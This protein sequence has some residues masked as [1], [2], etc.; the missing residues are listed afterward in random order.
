[1]QHS[2]PGCNAGYAQSPQAL[3]FPDFV[4]VYFSSR[5]R[6]P[7]GMYVS[8]VAWADFDPDFSQ[9]LRTAREPVLSRGGLGCFDEHGV[10]PISPLRHAGR[11][12]GYTTGWSRRASVSVDTGI[13]LVESLDG[14]AT[15]IRHHAGPVLSSSL[16]EP[17]LVGDGFVRVHEGVFHMWYI[18]GTG[19]KKYD[20][21][22]PPD[23]TYKIGHATSPDGIFWKKDEGRQII[24]DTLG[25][26]ES[27]A[28]P[29][30]LKIGRRWHMYFCYR[31][32]F[33]FRENS[34]RGYRLGYAWSDDMVRWVRDDE[35]AGIHLADQGWDSEMMCYP[36]LFQNAGRIWLLYNGNA[37]GKN[38]FGVAVLE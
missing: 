33:D 32:S 35:N 3:A 11:L 29:T 31:Q 36:H 6:E 24:S 18:F 34:S 26:Q 38:G 28:L 16:H 2:L 8:H 23:R 25:P 15:F 12:I 7:D 20:V 37:F 4:R 19:W 30:V 27:Q 10:F 9:V 13:G 5:E 22:S 14:G 1:M 21:N 17:N